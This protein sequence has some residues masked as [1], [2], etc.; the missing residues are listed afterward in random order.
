[1]KWINDNIHI[2]IDFWKEVIHYRVIGLD[3]H[4][5]YIKRKYREEQ[6]ENKNKQKSTK[7]FM[8]KDELLN[9]NEQ[10]KKKC[11]IIDE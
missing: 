10:T 3:E 1:M 4:Q 5:E 6:R 9:K 8:D 11:I 2:L 7:K